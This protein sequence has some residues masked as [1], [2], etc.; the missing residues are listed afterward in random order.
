[1]VA[2]GLRGAHNLAVDK[3]GNLYVSERL[4]RTMVSRYSCSDR[5][6]HCVL[7]HSSSAPLL[8]FET[9]GRT[10]FRVK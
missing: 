8:S 4:W 9:V 3:R 6:D 1:L 2:S 10:D 5:G 7:V